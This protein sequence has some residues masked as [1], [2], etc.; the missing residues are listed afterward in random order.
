MYKR[1]DRRKG[2]EVDFDWQTKGEFAELVTFDLFLQD[3][4]WDIDLYFEF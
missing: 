4:C 2:G 3:D 1:N